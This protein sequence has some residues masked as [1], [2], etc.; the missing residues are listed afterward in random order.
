[1]PALALHGP[2]GA[3]NA[4]GGVLQGREKG[5]SYQMEWVLA[6]RSGPHPIDP[7]AAGATVAVLRPAQITLEIRSAKPGGQVRHVMAGQEVKLQ[8]LVKPAAGGKGDP[9]EV[10][11][12]YQVHGP[13]TGKTYAWSQ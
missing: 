13:R 6:P 11:L 2:R 3:V 8:V 5:A 10:E 1:P 12:S 7:T 9:G 4:P